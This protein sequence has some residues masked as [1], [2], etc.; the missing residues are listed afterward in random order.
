[1]AKK[2]TNVF[3]LTSAAFPAY[4]AITAVFLDGA[5]LFAGAIPGTKGDDAGAPSASDNKIQTQSTIPCLAVRSPFFNGYNQHDPDPHG[6]TRI[7]ATPWGGI[8]HDSAHPVKTGE[9]CLLMIF[10]LPGV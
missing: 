10:K 2:K 1:M 9:L 8:C 5:P 3:W 6:A 4:L 7:G